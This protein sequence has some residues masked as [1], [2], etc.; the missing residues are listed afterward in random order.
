MTAEEIKDMTVRFYGDVG[1]VNGHTVQ[2]TER[3]GA[4]GEVQFHRTTVWVKRRGAWQCV[5]FHGSR[6]VNPPK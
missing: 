1:I 6:L 2:Q 4:K 3:A 5:S